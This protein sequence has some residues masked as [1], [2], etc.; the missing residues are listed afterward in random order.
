MLKKSLWSIALCAIASMALFLTP[1]T[2]YGQRGRG[3]RGGGGGSAWRGGGSAWRGG[4]GAWRGGY[5]G[6]GWGWGGFGTGLALGY[7]LGGWW[8]YPGWGYGGYYGSPYYYGGDYYAPGYSTYSAPTY[9]Y[10]QPAYGA[11][12]QGYYGNYQQPSVQQTDPNAADFTVLVP[13]PN[14]QIW[15]Q[16]H[17]TQQRGTVREFESSG[18]QPGQTYTFQIRTRFMQ[19]GQPVDQVR[20][21]QAQAGQHL[22]VDFNN[23][24]NVQGNQPTGTGNTPEH[25]N[26]G[27]AA[28]NTQ[29]AVP[30]NQPGATNQ[31]IE[32]DQ[33]PPRK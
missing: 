5:Y 7:G 30:P 25:R 11:T 16:D 32:K 31:G 28:A 12:Q 14:A 29:Q 22:T 24:G 3:G 15:F 19:N 33:T 20:K 8:G 26:T 9:Y 18:L 1:E 13:D 21:V 2:S 10:A 17:Q 23:P 6:R 4:G 27:P